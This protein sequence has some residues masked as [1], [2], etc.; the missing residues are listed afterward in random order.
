VGAGLGLVMA[1]LWVWE[2]R[3]GTTELSRVHQ[4]PFWLPLVGF[5][6]GFES[7]LCDDR[8]AE[9]LLLILAFCLLLGLLVLATEAGGS[10]TCSSK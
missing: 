4:Q 7:L 9:Y 5:R 8:P 3:G 10:G 1:L 2:T 6:L